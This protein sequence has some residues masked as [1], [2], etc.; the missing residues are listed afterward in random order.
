M[1]GGPQTAGQDDGATSGMEIDAGEKKKEYVDY[2]DPM[3]F[4]GQG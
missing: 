2:D 4:D 3:Q 1:G